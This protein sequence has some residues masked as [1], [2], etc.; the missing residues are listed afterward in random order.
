MAPTVYVG[1]P[2]ARAGIDFLSERGYSVETA[3]GL[4]R[5][6]LTDGLAGCE[7][8]VSKTLFLDE[9]LLRS[10]AKLRVIAKHGVGVD[11][12]VNVAIA[13]RLGIQVVNTPEANAVS[14]AEHIVALLLSLAKQCI[15]MDAAVRRGD[16]EAPERTPLVEMEG[17]L[18]GIVGLGRIGRLVAQ[19]THFGLG[20]RIVGFDPYVDHATLP[21]C[22]A[23]VTFDELLRQSDFVTLSVPSTEETRHLL[24]REALSAM[25]RGAC[26][27]NCARGEVVD[28]SALV[29][30]L[31]SGRIAAAAL[32]VF[33]P[34][35]PRRENPLLSLPN[36][37]LSP[38][39]AALTKEA[40]DRMSL[41]AAMGVHEVLTGQVP[42][43]PVNRV[44]RR[45][46]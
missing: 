26:L 6:E 4:T 29:G 14:V 16:F 33:D 43:W 1:Q 11:N 12:V 31:Q 46:P 7:A 20:M 45:R 9:N 2:I 28:E 41:H 37:I 35:P 25:K 22:I 32:D 18:L 24:D 44:S 13:G 34:E 39:C 3:T 10:A 30:E 40:L 5:E 42:T 21:G 38:H 19:K 36:V 17:K 8:V 23:P 15:P 27:V